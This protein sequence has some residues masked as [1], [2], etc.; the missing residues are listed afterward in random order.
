MY[1]S[2][3]QGIN[4]IRPVLAL[5]VIT[6][7]SYLCPIIPFIDIFLIDYVLFIGTYFSLLL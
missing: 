1:V 2:N 6:Y 4:Q 3:M 7:N 5:M